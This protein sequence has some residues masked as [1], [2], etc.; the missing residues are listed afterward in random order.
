M[1]S[2]SAPTPIHGAPVHTARVR[3]TLATTALAF[4]LIVLVLVAATIPLSVLAHRYSLSNVVLTATSL[5]FALVSVVVARHQPRNPLGWLLLGQA[6]LFVLSTDAALYAVLRYRLGYDG[7]PL[8]GLAVIL[9]STWAPGIVLLALAVLVLPDGRLPSPRW[10]WVWRVLI[11]LGA[12]C[13]AGAFAIAAGA[14]LGDK[15]E[16]DPGGAPAAIDHSTG[17]AVAWTVASSVFFFLLLL[18]LLAWLVGQLFGYRRASGERRL[19]LK[20]LLSGAA[21]FVLCALVDDVVS[22]NQSDVWQ[23]VGSIVSLG[24]I[25]LPL[26]IGVAILKFRLYEIDRLISRTVSYAI[27]TGLLVGVFAAVVTLSTH[28]LPFSSPVGVAAST[29]AGAALFNPL[30]RRVQHAVDRR[31]NRARYDAEAT[32]ADFTVIVQHAVDLD[33]VRSELLRTVGRSLEPSRVSLWTTPPGP[34]PRI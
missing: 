34:G 27:V 12:C 24:E 31:F 7:L 17:T 33:T 13:T 10:R 2:T 4:G 23:A 14:V 3:L 8:G 6:A 29:L 11:I 19:Q 28:V 1:Q 26:S 5:I 9:Q 32:V 18:T 21:S 16:I 20:W 15:L 22:T 30:R 25:A